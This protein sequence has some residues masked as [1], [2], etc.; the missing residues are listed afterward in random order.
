[1]GMAHIQVV[2]SIAESLADGSLLDVSEAAKRQHLRCPTF[3]SSALWN[4]VL[5]RSDEALGKV[6]EDVYYMYEGAF[7]FDHL[8]SR[9]FGNFTATLNHAEGYGMVMILADLQAQD[10]LGLELP[11]GDRFEYVM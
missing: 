6:L 10:K 2:K 5:K 7:G 1:M 4:G 11:S 8:G 9:D 3:L